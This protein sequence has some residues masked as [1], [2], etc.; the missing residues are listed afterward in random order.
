V[1]V[2][3]WLIRREEDGEIFRGLDQGLAVIVHYGRTGGVDKGA[4]CAYSVGG[5]D[6]V[7]RPDDVHFLHQ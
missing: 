5:I 2:E 1:R 7:L 6:E 4:D 3:C